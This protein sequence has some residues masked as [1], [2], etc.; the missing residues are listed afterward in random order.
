MPLPG[1]SART[2]R[3]DGPPPAP[4][5]RKILFYFFNSS[6]PHAS[7][8]LVPAPTSYPEIFLMYYFVVP[9]LPIQV[10]KPPTDDPAGDGSLGLSGS[11]G[12]GAA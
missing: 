8:I 11:G 9:G 4:P 2:Y 12:G 10:S 5:A 1:T 7:K 6:P 3:L